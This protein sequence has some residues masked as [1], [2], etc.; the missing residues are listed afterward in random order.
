[1]HVKKPNNLTKNT[2]DALKV[3]EGY[4]LN[5]TET[6][7]ARHSLTRFKAN[8]NRHSQATLLP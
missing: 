5:V 1:M 7:Q 2:V 8:M 3:L 6:T 4:I